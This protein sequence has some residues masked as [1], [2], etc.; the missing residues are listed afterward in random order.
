MTPAVYAAERGSAQPLFSTEHLEAMKRIVFSSDFLMTREKEQV[1]NLRWFSDLLT[2]PV[3]LAAGLDIR[4]LLSSDGQSDSLRREEF[5]ALSGIELDSDIDQFFYRD[6]DITDAS[7]AYLSEFVEQDDLFICYELS[8]ATRRLLTRMKITYIDIW[9]HPIRYLDDILFAFSSNH[10]EIFARI[11]ELNLDPEHYRLYAD[12]YRISTYKGHRRVDLPIAPGSALFVGQTLVDKAV[13][14]HRSGKMLNLLHFQEEFQHA[15]QQYSRV[16]YSRHPFVRDRDDEAI[17]AFIEQSP[18]AELATWPAYQMLGNDNLSHVFSIS[19]SV[20]HEARY[21][22]KSVEFLYRPVIELDTRFGLRNYASIYQELVSGHFWSSVLSPVMS[23]RE[24]ARVVFLDPKDKLRDMLAFYWSYSIVDKT[25]DMRAQLNAVDSRLQRLDNHPRAQAPKAVH[26]GAPRQYDAAAEQRK[27]ERKLQDFDVISFDVFDTLLVRPLARPEDLFELLRDQARDITGDAL[28]DLVEARTSARRWAVDDGVG[29]QG[30]EVP[31]AARYRALARRFGLSDEQAARLERLETEGDRKLLRP[32]KLGAALYH[33]ALRLGK[34]VVVVSDTY[35]ERPFIEELLAAH[36][37]RGYHRL[38]VSSETGTLKHSGTMF[39]TLLRDLGVAP[40]RIL[41][42]GDNERSDVQQA[43]AKG[44]HALHL[45]ST[46]AAFER[47]ARASR[48]LRA[49]D[50]RVDSLLRGMSANAVADNPL[51]I[52]TPSFVGGSARHLGYCIL[53][54]MFLGFARW[55]LESATR[56]RIDHL[57]FMARDGHIIRRAYDILAP[58][59]PD[60]PASTYLY[61]SRRGLTVPAAQTR[62]D[63]VAL[64][65]PNFSPTSLSMLLGNRFGI[66]PEQVSR[67]VLRSAGFRD[68]DEPVSWRDERL[69][70]LVRTMAPALLAIAREE[71]ELLLEHFARVGLSDESSANAIVDIGHNGTLQRALA[72]LLGRNDL[73]GYYFATFRN[74]DQVTARGMRASGYVGH[75]LEPGDVSHPYVSYILM[76]ELIFLNSEGSFLRMRRSGQDLRPELRPLERETQRAQLAQIL[77][78]GAVD[79]VRDCRDLYGDTLKSFE[80]MPE[81]LIAPYVEM[82]QRPTT[83]DAKIFEDVVFENVYSGRDLRYIVATN[84]GA[85]SSSV[86]EPVWR[87]GAEAL[88][89]TDLQSS[90]PPR[91]VRLF[92]LA[93]RVGL[94]SDRKLRKLHRDPKRFFA[95][96]KLRFMRHVS[97]FVG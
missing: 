35:Y 85:H 48:A 15:C 80:L 53:G 6:E 32:R 11:C 22:G 59:Y 91:F 73:G 71:R 38:Y 72:H 19:S 78:D 45:P 79:F 63:L 87:E 10:E 66:G 95:D 81:E 43:R 14:D 64:L 37:F 33:Q 7:I 77:H 29:L 58:L 24:A 74:I 69:P 28:P 52:D 49:R 46:M 5:F 20:V 36:G 93:N 44:L 8:E 50:R 57:Y 92:G 21:F 3:Q 30:E 12:R 16:Y 86:R 83:L 67:D 23:T 76:F 96:S 31:L 27:L 55:L 89:R 26:T 47:S 54:P 84:P 68:M 40:A 4:T 60:A 90:A 82:L 62:E 13:C 2:R 39:E 17:I 56:D 42:I 9:L 18:F 25:E 75:R 70:A 34:R 88:G 94:L 1:S 51:A 41:H 65:A 97:R 61:A